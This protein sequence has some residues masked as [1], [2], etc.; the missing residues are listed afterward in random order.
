M[1]PPVASVSQRPT[2][3]R[4]WFPTAG[5]ARWLTIAAVTLAVMTPLTLIV[6]QSLL[7]APFFMPNRAI[8]LEA[9]RFVF[10]D[11]DFWSA[12]KNSAF[13]AFGM[14]FIAL[15]LGGIL[16]FLMVRTDLPGRRWLEPLLLTPVFISPMVLGLGYVVSAGPAGF[17]STWW[18]SVLGQVPWNIYS[19]T[20]IV[21]IA[22]LTH[23]PHVYLYSSSALRNLGSDVEEAARVAGASPFRVARDVSLPMVMPSLLFSGVLVFFLGFEVFGLALVLGDP[24]GHLVLTTYLYKLTNK[25]GIPSYHLMAVVAVLIVAVTF[26]LVLLQRYLLRSASKYIT[27]KG[28]A[29]RQHVLPLGAW[30]WVAIAIVAAWLL[31]TVF[32]PLSGIVLR[33]F[34]SHWGEGVSLLSALTLANYT[35]LFEQDNMVRTILNTLGIGVFGGALA[36]ACYTAIGFASHRRHDWGARLMDYLVL[37]PRAV[38]GLLAGLAFL[39]VFLFVPGLKEFK[40]SMFCIWLAYMVVWLAYGMRLI[41]SA[42]MQVGPELEEAARSVGATRGQTSRYVTMPL[43]RFGLLASWLLIF[44]IFER[45]YSTAVYLLSPGTEVI[46]A[47]IVSLW[48]TGAVDQVAALSV[49]NLAMVG[50]GL[51]VAL[52]FGVKLHD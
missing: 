24:E 50:T 52:R 49:I 10:D 30:R 43:I 23:V 20:S 6:Y 26:P 1:A 11:S 13:V 38:P 46:G 51:A 45:E 37:V 48:A 47:V 8:S 2:V 42:L 18:Q 16:A 31:L 25:L 34:V 35:D 36:V 22:G 9:Y 3:L 15:P 17:Y 39:W 40:N 14:L 5:V 19:M 4:R 44:M 12:L 29:G 28:K 27:V 41:Q 7:N 33:S 21:I 32:V